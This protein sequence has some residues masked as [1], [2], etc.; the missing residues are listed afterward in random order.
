MLKIETGIKK[1][2]NKTVVMGPEGIGKST[3]ASQFPNPL[4][5]DTENG[6]STLNVRRILCNSSWDELI[7][8]V[9]EVIAE[10][11]ICKT[12]VIDSADWAENLAEADVCTKN[13]VASI[14]AIS[15][16]KGYTFV[17]DD[18]TRLLKLC[19]K[20]IELGINVTFTAH[21]KPRKFELPEEAGQFDRYEM[22]LSRQVAPLLK[23]WCDMLLFCNYKTYV[24][25]TEN[26]SKK[27]QGGKRVMYTSHHPCWDAK[28]RFNLPEEVDMDFSSIKHLFADSEPGKTPE[29]E[30]KPA[31]STP[32]QK[33][34]PLVAKMKSLIKEAGISADD[35]RKFVESKGHYKASEPL[36]DYS[37]DIISRWVIP[38]WKK[39]VEG[40]KAMNNGGN[41]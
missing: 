12:L 1:R 15:Y 6:T 33:D 2:A 36:E 29:I 27:A 38:H 30:K 8:I 22:K 4:F 9:N 31:E 5:I 19:D 24:V 41:R 3:L 13:R 34:R 11:T 35:F 16:G 7:A 21:A 25:T 20:L 40:V 23:E 10:P 28:N 39:I 32:I 26:N 37:D 18:F 17:A 14:E